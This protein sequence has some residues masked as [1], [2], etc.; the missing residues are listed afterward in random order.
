MATFV[1]SAPS[2][3]WQEIPDFYI[4]EYTGPIVPIIPPGSGM[5]DASNIK[6]MTAVGKDGKT[7][8]LVAPTGPVYFEE[9]VTPPEP[10]P[11][12][13]LTEMFKKKAE[14]PFGME[15]LI[16]SPSPGHGASS[17]P[18]EKITDK[19]EG[20]PDLPPISDSVFKS[21]LSS[22][23]TDNMYDRRLRGRTRG[24]LDMTRLP[25]VPTGATNVFAKKEARKNK[26]YNVVLV[27]DE[28][29]SM[30]DDNKIATAAECTA[31]LTKSLQDAH[32]DVAVVGFNQYIKLRKNFDQHFDKKKLSLLRSLIVSGP[33]Q[34]GGDNNDYDALHFAYRLFRGRK[35]KNIVIFMSDGM[36]APSSP[37]YF[38]K[39]GPHG[40]SRWKQQDRIPVDKLPSY[41]DSLGTY[42]MYTTDDDLEHL[43]NYTDR[44]TTHAITAL[45]N[46]H[47]DIETLGIG[48]Q[49]ECDQVP[50]ARVVNNLKELKPVIIH[51][52]KKRIK[53]G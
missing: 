2:G 31:F 30:I 29:G 38:Y 45:V 8:K 36:P 44:K 7:Y 23:M 49:S 25:K 40:A 6:E 12:P 18:E 20:N 53:R 24:K 34:G 27:V 10:K 50:G 13:S 39:E 22:I 51:E 4:Q 1:P 19:I 48:I 28:S 32:I 33:Y 15:M 5:L 47:K 35:G 26:K 37:Y 42:K 16:P 11:A 41:E 17:S 43:K 9:V 14:D 46:R 21:R 3:D 52:L